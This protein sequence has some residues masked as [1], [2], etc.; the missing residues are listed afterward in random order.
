MLVKI[1]G[2]RR[3]IKHTSSTK[4]C[5]ANMQGRNYGVEAIG[6]DSLLAI[7]PVP[8]ARK[9]AKQFPSANQYGKEA[10]SRSYWKG[11]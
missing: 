9:L 7:S 8:E 5:L 6:M 11:R 3:A 1:V 10:F 2:E 4:M